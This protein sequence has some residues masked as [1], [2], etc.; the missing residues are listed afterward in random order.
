[1][2]RYGETRKSL[3]KHNLAPKKRFGQNFLVHKHTAEAIV[4]AGKVA[5]ED[6]IVEVGV[7]LGALTQPLA[8][9]AKQVIGVEIDSGLIRFHEEEND[10][11][12][13]VT[14]IHEDVLKADFKKLADQCGGPMKIMANL[15]YSISNPFIFKLIENRQYVISATIM[16]QK[17]V[18]DRLMAAPGSKDYG[19]PS[20]L[21][22]SCA[23]IT[24]LM[25][26]KP[27][28]FHPQPKIDSTV[29]RIEFDHAP[30]QTR[31]GTLFAY[32]V[33]QRIV[34]SA[35]NQRRKT[36]HN[37]L[38]GAGFF[39]E[40]EAVD[41]ADNKRITEEVIVAAGLSPSLRPEALSLDQFMDLA[42][43]FEKR[44]Q[45]KNT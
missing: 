16:L 21:L 39:M 40:D 38:S 41:K 17:E 23:T 18:A 36:I 22:Q 3:G 44:L 35:F 32:P 12:E 15:P 25:T 7:G 43:S 45:A 42:V 30:F 11:P 20:V 4:R 19:V 24:G 27:S 14:L 1:M 28:E 34:R 5:A 26:L 37:T 29:I 13:N 33:F 31:Q 6:V 8:E 2:T 10:L 9:R